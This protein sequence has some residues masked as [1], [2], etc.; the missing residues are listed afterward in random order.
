MATIN[1]KLERLKRNVTNRTGI[2]SIVPGTVSYQF[3]ESVAYENMQIETQIQDFTRTKSL[4]TGSDID[5]DRIGRNFLGIERLDSELPFITESMKALK[6]YVATGT[7]GDIN[8]DITG[9]AQNIIIPEGTIIS[10][11]YNGNQIRFRVS[12]DFI[13]DKTLS[14]KFISAELITGPPGVIHVGILNSHNFTGYTQAINKRL[15]VTNTSPIT[16][17][18]EKESDDN[19]RFRLVN[20]LKAFPKTTYA[21]IYNELITIP[22]V[23][24][25]I[26]DQ[27]SNG[28]GSF[29]VYVQGITPITS[30][31]LIDTVNSKL[32]S[33]VGPWINYSVVK[34]RYIG[35]SCSIKITTSGSIQNLD[36]VASKAKIDIEN[37]VNNFYG[38]VIYFNSLL[39]IVQ[40][41]HPNILNATFNSLSFYSGSDEI[42]GENS[43]DIEDTNPSLLMLPKEKIIVEPMLNSITITM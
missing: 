1:D 39:K 17:G 26:I 33:I 21:G 5:L 12:K 6:L 8:L 3:L 43:I 36:A 10:G 20:G 14:E 13:L 9:Q 34:P 42:R 37:Y 23:S 27:S 41:A 22:G 18:R 4:A 32:A 29:T 31:E 19:Y 15:L 25:I 38:D 11:V 2:S 35:I 30:D 28:G 16:T 24:N 7:F 40:A